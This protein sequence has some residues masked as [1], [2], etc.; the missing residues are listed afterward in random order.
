MYMS[1]LKTK[2][3]FVKYAIK[4]LA[5]LG[6]LWKNTSL[7]RKIATEIYVKLRNIVLQH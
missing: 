4:T 7:K 2:L 5:I 1:F 3:L 6:L